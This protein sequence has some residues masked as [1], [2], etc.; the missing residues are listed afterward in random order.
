MR[1]GLRII[2]KL[3]GYVI[4]SMCIY[5]LFCCLLVCLCR[6]FSAQQWQL[7]LER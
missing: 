3:G 5:L 4:L 2:L 7:H 6:D 1:N